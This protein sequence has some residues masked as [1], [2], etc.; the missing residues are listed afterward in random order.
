M[1][2][3]LNLLL[4]RS[5]LS[6]LLWIL[7]TPNFSSPGTLKF[8]FKAFTSACNSFSMTI[9]LDMSSHNYFIQYPHLVFLYEMSWLL[10]WVIS[11][12]ESNPNT[13]LDCNFL[14]N[15][16][17]IEVYKLSGIYLPFRAVIGCKKPC[18]HK[19]CLFSIK[20]WLFFFV[21]NFSESK[22]S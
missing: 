19:G 22:C 12:F 14:L 18:S 9:F 3:Y 6:I 10:K 11:S 1:M 17:F 15:V 13:L 4:W 2:R 8:L 5:N 16:S 21:L 20:N 7:Q